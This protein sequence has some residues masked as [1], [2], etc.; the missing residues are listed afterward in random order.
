MTY[1]TTQYIIP[2]DSHLQQKW[3]LS[4]KIKMH[5]PAFKKDVWKFVLTFPLPNWPSAWFRVLL[6]QIILGWSRTSIVEHKIPPTDHTVSQLNTVHTFTT[7]FFQIHFN[8]ILPSVSSLEVFQQICFHVPH[9]L[10]FLINHPTVL[11]VL[12]IKIL[13]YIIVNFLVNNK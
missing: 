9:I 5:V 1:E 4:T 2:E 12:E 6:E 10:Y 3:K 7:Y 11:H 8:I 13:H